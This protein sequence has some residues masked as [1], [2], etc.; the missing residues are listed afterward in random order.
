MNE[1]FPV[2]PA[3]L[4]ATIHPEGTMFRVWAPQVSRVEVELSSPSATHDGRPDRPAD[5]VTHAL[6]R[7]HDGFHTAVVGHASAGTSYRYRLDGRGPFPDPASRWQP[8]GVHGPSVVVDPTTFAWTDAAWTGV[9]LDRLVLYELHIGTFT[10]GGTFA[11]A[12]ERLPWLADLGITAV[13]VMP[14]ADFPGARNWGYDGVAPFAPARGYGS[15]DA[16]RHFVDTAHA[17]GIAVHLDVVY[18]HLGPDGAYQSTFSPLFYS[19]THA[20]PWGAALNV[21]GPGSA[22]VRAYLIENARRWV[23]EFHVDG[24]RLDATHAIVDTSPRHVLADLA[25]AVREEARR[26]DRSALVIAEDAR[27]LD[28]VIRPQAAGGLGL[29]GVWADDF[30]HHVRRALA[31]DRDGYFADFDGTTASIAAT[32]RQGWFFTGQ[33]LPSTG[34]ARGTDPSGLAPAQFIFCLQNH[35]QVGNRAFG[36]RLHHHVDAAAW[37]AASTLLLVLPQT[38]LL[39]MGQEWAASTPFLYFTDHE[40]TLGACVTEGRRHEFAKFAAF[41]D[42][43]TRARIPDPQAVSTFTRSTLDWTELSREPHASMLQLYRRLLAL[44]RRIRSEA[45]DVTAADADT[46]VVHRRSTTGDDLLAIV[47][48]RASGRVTV[49]LPAVDADHQPWRVVL[50]T[51]DDDVAVDPQALTWDDGRGDVVFRRPGALVW[52]SAASGRS[53]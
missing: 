28:T 43:A 47:R 26:L 7:D 41:A 31:G 34:H 30:H 33:A 39:F 37:R 51:E 2:R 46:L 27:N 9:P 6:A 12:A 17:A 25:D 15:P 14:V 48:L 53:V 16:F 23:R 38:P 42:P 5:L 19:T 24:L 40:P 13:L 22:A 49:P 4:G 11:A 29:D 50:T 52:T 3:P 35:D 8:F 32:A 45:F 36:E 1:T 21:D 44:R 20:T 18:N 10:P